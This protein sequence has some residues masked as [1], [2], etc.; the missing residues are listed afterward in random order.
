MRRKAEY[1]AE[2]LEKVFSGELAEWL[3]AHP[4]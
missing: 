1:F 3:K 4:C 2:D